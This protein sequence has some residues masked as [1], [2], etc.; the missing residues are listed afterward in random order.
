MKT[1]PEF[2]E[3]ELRAIH[4]GLRT[5]GW[6]PAKLYVHLIT[7]CQKLDHTFPPDDR[8]HLSTTVT[9]SEGGTP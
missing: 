3:A 7:A 1:P 5:M 6:L 9:K 8:S 4:W 2:T